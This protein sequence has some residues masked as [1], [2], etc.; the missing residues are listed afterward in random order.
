MLLITGLLSYIMT[1][2]QI[3]SYLVSDE[4]EGWVY[5]ENWKGYE[6]KYPWC[7]ANI[8]WEELKKAFKNL[9]GKPE[10]LVSK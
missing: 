8:Y 10:V 5:M 7:S 4:I 1:V 2:Y 9:S 6:R 3:Q